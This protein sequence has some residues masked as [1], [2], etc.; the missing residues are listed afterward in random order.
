MIIIVEGIDR[1]G[2][3][4]LCDKLKNECGFE[5]F[6]DGFIAK[7]N[8]NEVIGAEKL[9]STLNFLKIVKNQNIVLDRFYLTEFVYGSLERGYTNNF[10]FKIDK[11]IAKLDCALV[12][13]KPTDI[14]QSSHNHGRDLKMHDCMFRALYYGSKIKNKT[15]I[16]YNGIDKFVE[17]IKLKMQSEGE[18]LK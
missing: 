12:L 13:V 3:T 18:Q 2:K 9:L 8:M 17:S 15:A 1:V 7:R 4:T 11:E 6:K 10:I 16:D 5:I 14:K